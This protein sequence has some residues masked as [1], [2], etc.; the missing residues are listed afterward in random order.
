M[1]LLRSLL[2][3]AALG[4]VWLVARSCI[5]VVEAAV[6]ATESCQLAPVGGQDNPCRCSHRIEP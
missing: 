1:K 4:C 6:A 2:L 5:P 3:V